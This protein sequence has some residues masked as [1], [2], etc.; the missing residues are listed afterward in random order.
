MTRIDRDM[1]V[2][3]ALF[4]LGA[5]DVKDFDA[6]MKNLFKKAEKLTGVQQWAYT[7]GLMLEDCAYMSLG[8]FDRDLKKVL[9]TLVESVGKWVPPEMRADVCGK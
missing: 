3:E 8:D 1:Q 4:I 5:R 6:F 9:A 7:L 2:G